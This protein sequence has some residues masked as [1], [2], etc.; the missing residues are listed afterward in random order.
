M[1]CDRIACVA[2]FVQL[3]IRKE[4][5]KFLFNK[6]ISI[7]KISFFSFIYLF[8]FNDKIIND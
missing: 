3:M 7:Q 4:E 1:W 8:I 5:P 6:K 2:V